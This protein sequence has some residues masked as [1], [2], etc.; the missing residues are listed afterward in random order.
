VFDL[1][2]CS[3]YLV[4]G[5][6]KVVV[7]GAVLVNGYDRIVVAAGALLLIAVKLNQLH[8]MLSRFLSFLFGKVYKFTHW[9][10]VSNTFHH[11]SPFIKL[12]F[13]FWFSSSLLVLAQRTLVNQ[14]LLQ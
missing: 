8:F 13:F 2:Y 14:K 9:I 6:D 4:V 3:A 12:A 10:S 5:D 11:N 7:A 1:Q